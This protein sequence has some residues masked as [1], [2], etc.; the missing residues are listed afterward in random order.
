MLELVGG[1]AHIRVPLFTGQKKA[2]FIGR[3]A[4]SISNLIP[5]FF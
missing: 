3:Y 2:E 1:V 4:T 5:D